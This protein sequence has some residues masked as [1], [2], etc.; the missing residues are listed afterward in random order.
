MLY[1]Y[2]L[3]IPRTGKKKIEKNQNTGLLC[4]HIKYNTAVVLRSYVRST[5]DCSVNSHLKQLHIAFTE[6]QVY[7]NTYYIFIN[8]E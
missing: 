2:L 8:T 3:L 5:H 7:R 4:K 6:T 1:F